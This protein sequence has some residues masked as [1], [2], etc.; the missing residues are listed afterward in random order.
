MKKIVFL[1]FFLILA[2]CSSDH[3]GLSDLKE[4]YPD[5]V[6]APLE[7]LSQEKQ[8][9]IGL[10][11]ELPFTADD[12]KANVDKD[13]VEMNYSSS[14]KAEVLVRTIFHPD[15]TIKKAELQIPLN[16]GAVAGVQE[17]DDFVYMEWYNNKDDILYQLK[18]QT[19]ESDK[20][21]QEA[22]EIANSI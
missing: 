22:L 17:K 5:Q 20:R 21:T 9:L 18:Y 10:P 7:D 3:L 15:N 13:Q 1:L 12:V 8:E 14:K 16:S 2:G 6:A 4:A 11:D 19:P